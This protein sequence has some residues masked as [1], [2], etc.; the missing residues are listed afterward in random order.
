VGPKRFLISSFSFALLLL[1]A[2]AGAQ[3]TVTGSEYR[4][5]A[6]R[7]E[8]N[9]V[10]WTYVDAS[11][12]F[13]YKDADTDMVNAGFS[14]QFSSKLI[15]TQVNNAT[16]YEKS[17][18]SFS[19]GA[20]PVLMKDLTYTVNARLIHGGGIG[21]TPAETVYFGYNLFEFEDNNGNGKYENGEILHGP[22]SYHDVGYSLNGNGYIDVSH[23]Y[24]AKPYVLGARSTYVLTTYTTTF[25]QQDALYDSTPTVVTTHENFYNGVTFQA[26]AL[27]EPSTWAALG[28]GTVA[29]LRR[30]KRA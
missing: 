28:L 17:M 5:D 30:R 12:H 2:Q 22:G 3:L 9:Y 27:P 29:L 23:Q 13:G 18:T 16:G 6:L 8:P 21:I 4:Y 19:I 11:D 1:A 25:I 7:V 26:Q 10:A 24:K 20:E 15:R 14:D